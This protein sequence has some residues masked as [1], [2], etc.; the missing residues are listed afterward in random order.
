MAYKRFIKSIGN[1]NAD[2]H[3]TSWSLL[4]A[5]KQKIQKI[6]FPKPICSEIERSR[7]RYLHYM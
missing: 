2:N 1:K 7:F 5:S 3:K 6:D 4:E